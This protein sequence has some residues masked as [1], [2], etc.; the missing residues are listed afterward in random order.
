MHT[1]QKGRSMIEMLGVLAI[2]GILSVGGIAGYSKAMIKAK[3]SRLIA[4]ASELVVN[5]RSLYVSQKDFTGLTSESLLKTGAV[6]KDMLKDSTNTSDNK[7]IHT[8]GGE[9]IV[10]QSEI[11]SGLP[12][13]FEIYLTGLDSH[14]CVALA[15]MDWGS[16]VSSGFQA[17]YVGVG[18]VTAPLLLNVYNTS[19][20]SPSE[21]IYTAGQHADAVPLS[22][23][24]A[25]STCACPNYECVIGLKYD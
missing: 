16:D 24:A 12:K 7:I 13:A 4:Q 15:T 21:G 2:V 1:C 19:L 11:E 8:Y 14:T 3:S 6:P 20:S 22:V 23:A 17:I 10:F 5:I 18:E 25:V 9:I